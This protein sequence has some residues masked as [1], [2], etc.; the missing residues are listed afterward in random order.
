[1]IKYFCFAPA[2][3]RKCWLGCSRKKKNWKKKNLF[4]FAVP[5]K[6]TFQS[7]KA[8]TCGQLQARYCTNR[9]PKKY[10]QFFFCKCAP[11]LIF[12]VSVAN[13]IRFRK[14]REQENGVL[15]KIP[16]CSPPSTASQLL[17]DGN[18]FFIQVRIR[19]PSPSLSSLTPDK[20]IRPKSQLNGGRRSIVKVCLARNH[21]RTTTPVHSC[22]HT[23]RTPTHLHLI[24]P[25]SIR[26]HQ[27]LMNPPPSPSPKLQTC[28][29]GGVG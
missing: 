28:G 4:F 21:C 27:A 5:T 15:K 3:N 23:H 25:N 2:C 18:I 6:K 26:P 10:L 20:D 13:N 11:P 24:T 9:S 16:S 1:M 14:W 12:G 7:G 22:I 29:C 8:G 17:P 19:I